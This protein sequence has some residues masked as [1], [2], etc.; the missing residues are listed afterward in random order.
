MGVFVRSRGM[1]VVVILYRIT[2][3]AL[4]Q[5]TVVMLHSSDNNDCCSLPSLKQLFFSADPQSSDKQSLI[6]GV[7]PP[8]LSIIVVV[9]VSVCLLSHIIRMFKTSLVVCVCVFPSDSS[10]CRIH[11]S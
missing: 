10:Q 6:L 11:L 2:I 9:V 4:Q 8:G 3:A 1:S 7:L 5:I